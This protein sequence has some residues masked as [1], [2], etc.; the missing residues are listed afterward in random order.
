MVIKHHRN[1]KLI[2]RRFPIFTGYVFV[3]GAPLLFIGPPGQHATTLGAP[4]GETA[5]VGLTSRRV[6]LGGTRERKTAST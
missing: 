5:P 3:N 6:F 4:Q 2:E 1:H